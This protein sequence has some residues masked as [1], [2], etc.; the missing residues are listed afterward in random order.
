MCFKLI[1]PVLLERPFAPPPVCPK[2]QKLIDLCNIC[3]S[4]D[5]PWSG[6]LAAQSNERAHKWR[7]SYS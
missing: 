1:E 2:V 3:G 4:K 6:M 5:L 7:S